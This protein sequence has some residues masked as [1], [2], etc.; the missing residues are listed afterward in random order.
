[1]TTSRADKINNEYFEWMYDIA[2]AN[3][4][5]GDIS[6]R[7]LFAHL[8]NTEFRYYMDRDSGRY[9]DGL[10]LRYEFGYKCGIKDAERYIEGPCSVLEM[11]VAL[12]IICEE[13]IMD[14][15]LYGDRTSQWFWNMITNIGLGAMDDSNFDRKYVDQVVDRFLE[16]RYKPNGEGGLFTINNADRDLRDVE[17]WWQLCWYLN[18]MRN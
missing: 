5:P 12:A 2:C 7:K 17:I 6:Y 4:L 10:D 16:R 1:M 18:N 15:V 8:H 13:R 9:D 14:N 3:R 11:I